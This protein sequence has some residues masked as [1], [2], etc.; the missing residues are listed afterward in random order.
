MLDAFYIYVVPSPTIATLKCCLLLTYD[1]TA[2]CSL[3]YDK[4]SLFELH[5]DALRRIVLRHA[6]MRACPFGSMFLDGTVLCYEEN[7][8]NGLGLF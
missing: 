4:Q 2:V 8:Q 6:D 1:S 5:V 3:G 7:A